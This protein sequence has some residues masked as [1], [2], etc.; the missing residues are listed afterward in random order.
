LY[1]KDGAFA[2]LLKDFI[3]SAL[4]VELEAHVDQEQRK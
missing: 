3:E 2:P 1:G 4:E